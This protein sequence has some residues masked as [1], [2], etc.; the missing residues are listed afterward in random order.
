MLRLISTKILEL[1]SKQAPATGIGLFRLFYGL[2]TF[3]EII[4]LLYFNHLIFDPIPY[5]D[6]EFPMIPF[7][8]CLWGIIAG[9]L[10]VGYR[11]QFAVISNYIF[12]IIFVNFTSM[13][14]DFDGGFDT[15]MIGAGF[16]LLFMPGDRAFSIDSLRYKLSTPFT[17]Y[18]NY[19]KPTV[20]ALAYYLPVAICLG[21]LYFDS[22]V[23]KLFAEHWRN[24]LGTWLPATQPYYVSAIDM[25]YLLNNKLLQ[26]TIGYII[27]IFQFTFIF[28]FAKR[29]LRI[30]YLL[31]GLGLH[32]G[33]TLSFNIYPFGLGMVCFYTLMIPFKWWRCIGRLVTSK[34]PSLTVFY[35]QL[36]PLC[37]RTV[38]ILNHFDIFS[39]IDFKSA[40]EHA[41]RYPALAAINSETLLTDLYAL[42]STGHIYSGID[43]YSR[44]FIKMRYLF[45]VGII[46]GL[47]GI[48][49][50]AL[51][52]YRSIADM[53]QRI[54]CSSACLAPQALPD[55]S[56]YHLLFEDVASKKPNAFSRKLSKILIAIFLLQLN[57][58]IHYGLIYRLDFAAKK[59]SVGVPIAEA[60]NAL[61]NVSLTFLGITPHAL[62]LHDHF[63]GYDHILAITYTDSN[64]NE[65]WLPFVNEQGRLLAPNWGRVHSMWANIAVTPNI[66]NKR[67]HKFIMKVTAFWAQKTGL[68]IENVVFNIK[69]KK[70]SAPSYWVYDQLHLN[71][72]SPWTT[73]GTAKWRDNRI[74]FDLPDNINEL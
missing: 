61:L 47:P 56:L 57:S 31:V 36:C 13:Q 37:N 34:Q 26:N 5:I 46:L 29:Q 43:T 40:Q 28:F 65:H 18:S 17:H 50:L 39:C 23:H 49:Q 53:R 16:F 4:F 6:V 62:Y 22:A 68:N 64:G 3:Q 12:W 15:F 30:A 32:L 60:S 67:L 58:T 48:H 21:F 70:I 33:I 27:L 14:R 69:L 55:T 9:F 24:G 66:N 42:D 19:P 63:A 20:S 8:L 74:S 25:S 41:A 35:D 72:T 45:P 7:F 44:I 2:I 10:I 1:Y 71:F 11:Y 73:I 59:S 51:K 38:L 52:K 54:S